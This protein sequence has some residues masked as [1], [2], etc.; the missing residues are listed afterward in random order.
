MPRSRAIAL[1]V[2]VAS[3][4]LAAAW[5][6]FVPGGWRL[7]R[8]LGADEAH[9]EYESA[10]AQRLADFAAQTPPARAFVFLGS[11][12]IE[13]FDLARWFPLAPALDRGIGNEPLVDLAS[14]A[15]A[16]IP[17]DA[18]ALV[19]YAGSI[20]FRRCASA[21]VDALPDRIDRLLAQLVS[22]RPGCELVVLGILP[23]RAMTPERV[24]A[25]ARLN[26]HLADHAH[27]RGATFVETARPPLAL[28]HG[29]LSEGFSC[30]SLHLSD[31]GYAV[32]AGWIAEALPA[33]RPRDVPTAPR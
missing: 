27:A 6:D 8:M 33:L 23:E 2:L 26:A 1:L 4:G 17:T 22:E 19:L 31:D 29:A 28:A 10:R 21:E 18:Q 24:A 3:V 16:S 5:F 13:R 20:D 12:T 32:L 25:L 15:L 9:S 30:D 11:S 7:R 14:R